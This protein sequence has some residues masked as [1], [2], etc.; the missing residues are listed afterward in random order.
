MK[1]LLLILV[2]SA[3]TLVAV[4]SVMAQVKSGGKTHATTSAK[5]VY[6][7]EH[8]NMASM[9]KGDCPKCKMKMTATKAK[10]AYACDHCKTTS[11]KMG[12][13]PKCKM[14]MKPMAVTYA[15]DHC[16]TS[17]AKAGDCPKCKMEMKKKMT[18]IGG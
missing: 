5:K 11:A 15:C 7:C 2:V 9:K 6:M 1:K 3:L 17:S 12:D 10:V 14:A 4:P 16:K 8:C 18:P 13:C